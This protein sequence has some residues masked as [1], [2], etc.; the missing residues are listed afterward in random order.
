M[1][2]PTLTWAVAALLWPPPAPLPEVDD[3]EPPASESARAP[4]PEPEP[5]PETAPEPEPE[6]DD[7]AELEAESAIPS[8]PAAAPPSQPSRRPSDEVPLDARGNPL[9]DYGDPPSPGADLPY[10]TDDD[11]PSELEYQRETPGPG[12]DLDYD[13]RV[14]REPESKEAI[15][16]Q[17]K[18]SP[19]TDDD[20][21]ALDSPQRFALELKFGPY[22]PTVDANSGPGLGPYAEIFGVTSEVGLAIGE[23][24]QAVFSVIGFEWQFLDV[25]GPLSIG[26][27]V[28]LF[29]DRAAGLLV[30]A[31]A[32]GSYRSKA[33]RVRFGVVP[34]TLLLGYRFELLADRFNVP[35]VPYARGG[36]GYG[37]WWSRGGNKKVSVDSQGNKGRGG[38]VGWQ[39]NLGMMLR[40]DFIDRES[41]RAL[42]RATGINHTYIFG[43]YMISR[44]DGFGSDKRMSV[45]D[46]T[47]LVGLAI[48]F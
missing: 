23:P 1:S 6:P 39:A 37:F 7:S 10:A 33:D 3:D 14:Q 9:L 27:T 42:D 45:G 2:G 46:D 8:P 31:D 19:A 38:S 5:E 43:E 26:T 30:S 17:A 32:E 18:R 48:A 41:I 35:L 13:T 20:P 12:D 21:G 16:R 22:L 25:G 29:R 44:L 40:L 34:V 15:A 36:L 47:W 24:K 4:A 11:G 28:G